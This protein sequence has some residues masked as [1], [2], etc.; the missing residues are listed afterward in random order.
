MENRTVNILGTEYK[1]F[2]KSV[3]EDEALKEND[4]AG[5][6]CRES[7]EIIVR[8][9]SDTEAGN[10]EE[11]TT[12]RH[13]IVHAFLFESGLG[14]DWRRPYDIGHNETTVDWFAIQSPKIFK[15]YQELGVLED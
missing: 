9:Q 10:R 4:L 13:E 12:V 15:V 2:F 6:C 1:V 8:K 14:Y 7:R 3:E 11:K 5:Y